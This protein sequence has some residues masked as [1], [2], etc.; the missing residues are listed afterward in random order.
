MGSV[1][2]F[3]PGPGS[4]VVGSF[5]VGSLVISFLFLSCVFVV[6]DLG[7]S[8][9]DFRGDCLDSPFQI[10]FHGCILW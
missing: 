3:D 4:A 5:V 2:L 6:V 9:V 1:G 7:I 10:L 8:F